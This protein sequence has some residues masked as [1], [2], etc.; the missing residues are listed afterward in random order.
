MDP[1][2]TG[3]A[4]GAAL[5]AVL[6]LAAAA[7]PL[8]L[9]DAGVRPGA[10]LGEYT[11]YL[12]ERIPALMRRYS[13]PGASLAL[14]EGG[15]IVWT[16]AYGYADTQTGRKLTEGTALRAQSISKSV[17]AW[18]VMKLAQQG[19]IDLD[20]P[21]AG[22][23]KTWSFPEG[24]YPADQITIR[25]LLSHT[26]GLP[27]GDV[28]AIYSPKDDIPS[29]RESLTRTAIPF[30]APGAG[31][32]YSN[33]GY[34]LLELLIED[35]SGRDFA[36]YMAD[37]VLKPLGMH[38]ST[39]EWSES[40]DPPLPNGYSLGGEAVPVYVYPEKASG[41]LV[42][43]AADI[44]AFMIAGMPD[45]SG[46]GV[47]SPSG[48][49]SLYAP[50]AVRLGVYGLAFDAY[51]SGYYTERLAGTG[52]AVS[53]GGQGTGW[54]SHF[55]A[56]PK[57]GD[58]IVILT[59]SQRSWPFIASLLNGWTHWRGFSPPGMARI[60]YAECALWAAAGLILSSVLFLA[61]GIIAGLV[62]GGRAFAPPR[63]GRAGLVHVFELG[64]CIALAA[65][66]AWCASQKYLFLTSVF[67]T[68]SPW[69]GACAVAAAA[70]LSMAAFFP[71]GAQ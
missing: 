30:Q 18:G 50:Q 42:A 69:L 11:A 58:G 19:R 65:G 62:N 29:L 32:S 6:F 21:V 48:V 2:R 13:V 49:E 41:G 33:V 40:I 16:R 57:T 8:F 63:F 1:I 61:A 5:T 59:N 36:G 27:L 37:E 26:A 22:Y 46:R 12:E 45:F 68:V 44:A 23:L 70:A 55:H 9:P 15:K 52:L 47:L 35:V 10:A 66:F 56:V 17:T 39:F 60:L 38:D 14:V 34:N 20:A 24:E 51:G 25:Q 4:V 3:A 43:T 31:F 53:H 7:V 67:P 64:A 54:M 71:K 28:L